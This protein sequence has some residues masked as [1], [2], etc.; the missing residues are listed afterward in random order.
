MTVTI[1]TWTHKFVTPSLSILSVA[2]VTEK[3]LVT[4]ELFVVV[5]FG[6]RVLVARF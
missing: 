4:R 5:V 1:T 2:F 3:C 6:Y